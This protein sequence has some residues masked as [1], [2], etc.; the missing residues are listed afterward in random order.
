[1]ALE[2]ERKYLVT[3]DAFKKEATGT[4]RM[5]QGYLCPN[6]GKTVRVRI[7]EEHAWLTIK[8]PSADGGLSR[9]EWEKEIS[10]EDARALLTLA[11]DSIIDK[12]RWLVPAGDG[13]HTW[14]VDEF[15]GDNSGL[16]VA[17]I[18]LSS[19]LETYP[20]PSWLGQEVTGDRR[21]YNARLV[22]VPYKD[23]GKE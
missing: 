11:E 3:S 23:W 7:E 14:E 21:Y 6:S 12:T 5:I 2:I 8:G 17:E 15:Y 1:M 10:E 13:I 9:F 4:R 16:V 22:K 18:E 19:P 20:R